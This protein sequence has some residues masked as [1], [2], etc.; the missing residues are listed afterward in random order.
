M[1]LSSTL[2]PGYSRIQRRDNS[3]ERRSRTSCTVDGLDNDEK[4]DLVFQEFK[5]LNNQAV[6]KPAS[7]LVFS[8][9]VT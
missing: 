3:M 1:S 2:L 7:Y 5:C 9:T 6:L 4:E 8:T